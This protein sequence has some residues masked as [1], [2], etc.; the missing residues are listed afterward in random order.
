LKLKTNLLVVFG[1]VTHIAT[2]QFMSSSLIKQVTKPMDR[3][4]SSEN[5]SVS[6]GQEISRLLWN[7]KV[8][9]YSQEPAI[10]PCPVAAE[11][12]PHTHILFL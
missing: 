2:E 9:N 4:H 3:I 7:P 12:N 6:A 5:D 10:G 11:S 8:H 1:R